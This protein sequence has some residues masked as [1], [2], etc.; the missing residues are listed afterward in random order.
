MVTLPSRIEVLPGINVA[1]RKMS[2]SELVCAWNN[3]GGE[4]FQAS[5]STKINKMN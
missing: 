2:F 3:H 5:Y 4:N 1:V